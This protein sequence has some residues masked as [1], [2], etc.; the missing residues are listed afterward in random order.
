MT[1][2]L[3]RIAGDKLFV[4]RPRTLAEDFARFEQKVPGVFFYLGVNRPGADPATV[5]ENHSPLFYVDE[6]ALPTGVRALANM[7]MDY[8]RIYAGR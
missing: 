2:T 1:P 8:L 3:R 5:A 7:A 4:A 6:G